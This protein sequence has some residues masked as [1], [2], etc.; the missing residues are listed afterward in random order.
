MA[1]TYDKQCCNEC[2]SFQAGFVGSLSC[3]QEWKPDAYLDRQDADTVS[4]RLTT[5]HR[6]N[7]DS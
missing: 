3:D 2:I 6:G 7:H 4:E 5:W 1:Y